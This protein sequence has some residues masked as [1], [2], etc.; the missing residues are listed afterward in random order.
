MINDILLRELIPS[1]VNVIV[2]PS[3]VSTNTDGRELIKSGLT[4]PALIVADS[5]TG[6]RGRQGKSFLSPEG[7][8]YMSLVLRAN[9][10]IERAMG[11]T[12]CSGVCVCRAVE[13]LCSAKCG[14][15]WINDIYL[16]EKKLC[17]ILAESV[18]DYSTMISKYLVVGIGVNIDSTPEVTDSSVRAISLAEAGFTVSKE[19][20]CANIT[21]E[22][23]EAYNNK[24][25]F[26]LYLEEYKKR[27]V[28]LGREISFTENGVTKPCVAKDI[29][30]SGAL[31]VLCEGAEKTLASGEVSVRFR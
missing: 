9:I 5:Q 31:V 7:G 22:L 3:T 29:T 27:S 26:T 17:G 25:D 16:D 11:A 14:I 28:I 1:E 20:L 2:K 19:E 6:G 23:L 21:K 4:T 12:S 18:N 24:F 13:K 10:P 8:L 30:D 15:K